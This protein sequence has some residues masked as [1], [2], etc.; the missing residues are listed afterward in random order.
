LPLFRWAAPD[1]FSPVYSYPSSS[2]QTGATPYCATLILL[3]RK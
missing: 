2:G 1:R 3:K